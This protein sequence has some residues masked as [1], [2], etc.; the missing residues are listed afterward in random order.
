MSSP[1]Q[2]AAHW[3]SRLLD[4][5]TD[6]P[7]REAFAQWLA[8]DP[9]HAVEYEAFA[10][11]WGNFGNTGSAQSMAS[12]MEH[13]SRR[14]FVR[15]GALGGLLL[16][17]GFGGVIAIRGGQQEQ[18]LVTSIGE[19]RRVTLDDGS[20]VMLD[21]DTLLH[22]MQDDSNRKVFL[23]RGRAIFEV[24]HAPSR[25]FTVDA[26]AAQVRVLGTRFVVE[27]LEPQVRVSVDRGLVEV[28]GAGQRLQLEA[29]QVAELDGRQQLQRV[30]RA[31]ANA[32]SFAEGSL[33]F[34]R[35]SLGE[36]AS[37]LSRYR[38]VPIKAQQP[39][40]QAITAVVQIADVERFVALLPTLATVQVVQR[41]G[42]TWLLPR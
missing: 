38:N 26:G 25:P 2:Q 40:S 7:D 35:A 16:A 20:V 17:V 4:L 3:F 5:P 39:E 8:A 21:A 14:R 12:A 27:R 24:R 34:E 23:L 9:Q 6:H 11:L 18:I 36:I 33:T 37:S 32:F 15:N 41:D 42:T 31:A 1:R 29:G 10:R 30:S 19:R 22:V 13:L 28:A